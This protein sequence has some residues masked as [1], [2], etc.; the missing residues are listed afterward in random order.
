MREFG[1]D[2]SGLVHFSGGVRNIVKPVAMALEQGATAFIASAYGH[3]L[4]TFQALQL[5][6][7]RIPDDV[8]L[9]VREERDIT[10]YLLPQPTLLR[11][12]LR[13]LAV[14]AVSML[15]ELIGGRC[16]AENTTIGYH[17]KE[18]STTAPVPEID[19]ITRRRQ[20][21]GTQKFT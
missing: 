1:L 20:L 10:P 14:E 17:L 9:V 15:N 12:D 8:S 3:A 6:G 5:L 13:L 11:L 21:L 4:P 2:T 18:G 7:C 16:M 19:F